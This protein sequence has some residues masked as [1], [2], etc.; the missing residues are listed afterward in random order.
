MQR[1]TVEDPIDD[2]NTRREFPEI[3]VDRYKIVQHIGKGAF[4]RVFLAYT[5][6]FQRRAIKR[7][8]LTAKP[9]M[10]LKEIEFLRRLEGKDNIVQIKEIRFHD[11]NLQTTVITNYLDTDDFKS[12]ILEFTPREIQA[13]MRSLLTALSHLEKAPDPQ[14]ADLRGIL[15]RDVKPGNFLFE[16]ATG[17][18]LLID[19]GLAQSIR[20]AREFPL[21]R[22]SK[23]QSTQ[24]RPNATDFTRAYEIAGYINKEM[25]SAKQ[26]PT[27]PHSGTHGYRAPE[28]LVPVRN[29]DTKIDSWSAGVILLQIITGKTS[30]FRGNPNTD[31]YELLAIRAIIGTDRF[32]QGMSR[33]R[34]D[35][36]LTAGV[37]MPQ[38]ISLEEMCEWYNPDLLAVLPSTAFDLCRQLLEF[39]PQ[40][41][42]SASQAL[43]HPFLTIQP[44]LLPD[45]RFQD[46]AVNKSVIS[47]LKDQ[48]QRKE[49]EEAQL[50]A[51]RK[52]SQDIAD[53]L[54]LCKATQETLAEEYSRMILSQMIPLPKEIRKTIEKAVQKYGTDRSIQSPSGY[55]IERPKPSDFVFPV[56]QAVQDLSSCQPTT[57]AK[58]RLAAAPGHQARPAFCETKVMGK[59]QEN[60]KV[61]EKSEDFLKLSEEMKK[62]EIAK[63]SVQTRR[64]VYDTL[65]EEA[66]KEKEEFERAVRATSFRRRVDPWIQPLKALDKELRLAQ[67]QVRQAAEE[68]RRIV[69]EKGLVQLDQVRALE[70]PS[71]KVQVKDELKKGEQML[72]ARQAVQQTKSEFPTNFT[73]QK[74]QQTRLISFM[75]QQQLTSQDPISQVASQL[76]AHAWNVTE[77]A[78][79]QKIST[80]ETVLKLKELNLK[81]AKLATV[82]HR[83][84]L[85]GPAG[86]NVQGYSYYDKNANPD[87]YLNLSYKHDMAARA[88]QFQ[89]GIQMLQNELQLQLDQKE[90]VQVFL[91]QQKDEAKRFE[92][93]IR[94]ME[95]KKKQ[96]AYKNVSFKSQIEAAQ[97]NLNQANNLAE[98]YENQQN[99]LTKQ[100]AELREKIVL[101]T[102]EKGE[103]VKQYQQNY[104]QQTPGAF[105]IQELENTSNLWSETITVSDEFS[106]IKPSKEYL[107]KL[108]V[109]YNPNELQEPYFQNQEEIKKAFQENDAIALQRKE[110]R[111]KVRK[112]EAVKAKFFDPA[113]V[114]LQDLQDQI[115]V[116]RKKYIEK[117]VKQREEQAA[118]EQEVRRLHN[119]LVPRSIVEMCP[120][121]LSQ[122]VAMNQLSTNVALKIG[123]KQAKKPVID[124]SPDEDEELDQEKMLNTD[125]ILKRNVQA[126]IQQ[127]LDTEKKANALFNLF[128]SPLGRFYLVFHRLISGNASDLTDRGQLLAMA[129]KAELPISN[130]LIEL[131]STLQK[132][133]Q[134]YIKNSV[135]KKDMILVA[136]AVQSELDLRS[137]YAQDSDLANLGLSR[138]APNLEYS[139]G[140]SKCFFELGR[141]MKFII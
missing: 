96:D 139:G 136:A 67:R 60:L 102:N 138:R 54:G 20:E 34:S 90:Q 69:I 1:N 2:G 81:A 121:M 118:A 25:T 94:L 119:D 28:I 8:R 4:S 71:E 42:L 110:R 49:T 17:K 129:K 115:I 21:M 87:E 111:E 127:H 35:F 93:E 62:K 52:R 76:T 51:L 116:E 39:D 124:N 101:E 70:T 18:G 45:F 107:Q 79:L 113:L 27:Q 43:Q 24:Q 131:Q 58:P 53:L 63:M 123:K 91:Q 12:I 65:W 59:I 46:G 133:S 32:I 78:H 64:Q 112:F 95:N 130:H 26:L 125:E 104:K 92:Q 105:D 84:A 29:Q 73:Q 72:S 30:I 56:S 50:A 48:Q 141:R 16:R 44:A 14:N 137:D 61:L 83:I 80:D 88:Y 122:V 68:Y 109:E 22:Q 100:I 38:S 135:G 40:R 97:V 132:L 23:R 10:L 106:E 117:L 85:N 41:R 7:I 120:S 114:E 36:S 3:P 6:E 11:V 126:S 31:V 108:S 66:N 140:P 9:H 75:L 99:Q 82:S 13:Y 134:A 19:F 86:W 77:K 55:I 103:Y 128:A 33:L 15:H 98:K 89:R 47:F 37:A 74:I 57:L 5:P